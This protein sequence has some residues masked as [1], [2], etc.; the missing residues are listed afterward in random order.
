[1]NELHRIAEISNRKRATYTENRVLAAVTENDLRL[2]MLPKLRN[3]LFE[4]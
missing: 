4:H 1:M 3:L 2:D